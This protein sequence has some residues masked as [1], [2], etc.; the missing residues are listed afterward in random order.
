MILGIGTDLVSIERIE[1]ILQRHPDRFVARVFTAAERELCGQRQAV[2]GGCWA[3]RF[4]A[5]EALVKALGTGMRAGIWFTDI[6]IL[7]DPLGRPMMSLS[8]LAARRLQ[9][10]RA[11]HGSE[12][13]TIHL[14]L[15]DESG[16]ALA[17]VILEGY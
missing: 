5:K 15:A 4:A 1:G 10:I 14:S 8:G 6:E 12:K 17:Y 2:A 9:E 7:N 16:F 11:A 3:K 13:V